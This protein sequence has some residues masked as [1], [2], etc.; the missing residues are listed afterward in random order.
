[1]N[2]DINTKLDRIIQLLEKIIELNTPV[3]LYPSTYVWP[4]QPSWQWYNQ[5]VKDAND[6]D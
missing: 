5:P 2:E 1:M 3:M 6:C 4:N